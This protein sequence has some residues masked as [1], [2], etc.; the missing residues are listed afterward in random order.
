MS[1]FTEAEGRRVAFR[2]CLTSR[3]HT[4]FAESEVK[5]IALGLGEDEMLVIIALLSITLGPLRALLLLMVTLH[6]LVFP[7]LIYMQKQK[8]KAK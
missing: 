4:T 2:S 8:R 6:L 7:N 1:A 5:G 3:F